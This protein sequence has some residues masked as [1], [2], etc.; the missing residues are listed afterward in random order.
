MIK[1]LL[2]GSNGFIGNYIKMKYSD[3][4]VII[5]DRS[6][7]FENSIEKFISN[8]DRYV[9]IHCAGLAHGIGKKYTKEDYWD[10]NVNLTK[11]IL[12]KL[13]LNPPISVVFLSTVAV[14]G[15]DEGT[16]LD[17]NTKLLANS[18]Y[19]QSKIQA[20][21]EIIQWANKLNI[22][23][24]IL[25]LPLVVG[26]NA[27]GNLGRMTNAIKKRFFFLIGKGAAKK[28]MV[29]AQDIADYILE[30]AKVG[31]IYNVTDGRSHSVYDLSHTIAKSY[32]I[33][34]IPR[35]PL[36][37]VCFIAHIGDFLGYKFIFNTNVL[38]KLTSDLTF[39]DSLAREKVGWNPQNV[40]EFYN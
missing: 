9:F 4:G 7:F 12:K 36:V 5:L 13:E 2:S 19:S 10:A 15:V 37:F 30:F 38:R 33:C 39:N 22:K 31:G 29:L 25:R 34:F 18:F 24:S 28:S 27:P 17:E 11:K 8:D 23:Y 40:L 21:A 3:Q 32:G 35:I 1:I 20:E 14:Y 16:N 26:F 6:T